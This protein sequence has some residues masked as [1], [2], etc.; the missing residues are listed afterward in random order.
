MYKKYNIS[1][2][3]QKEI[4]ILNNFKNDNPEKVI[5]VYY[6]TDSCMGYSLIAT[7]DQ[8]IEDENG[9]VKFANFINI[10]DYE[11]RLLMY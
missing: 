1:H 3:T 6:V 5:S 10:T 11:E 7:Y 2:C 9:C 4:D 8:P